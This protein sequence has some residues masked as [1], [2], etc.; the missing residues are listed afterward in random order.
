MV[1]CRG[2]RREPSVPTVMFPIPKCELHAAYRAELD[3][4][5]WLPSGKGIF[6]RRALSLR[7]LTWLG[8]PIIARKV[9]D[10][11]R[12]WSLVARS[13]TCRVHGHARRGGI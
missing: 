11:C 10:V 6:W 9:D 4:T 5:I 3:V 7:R 12:S 13:V 2:V 1:L 8:V